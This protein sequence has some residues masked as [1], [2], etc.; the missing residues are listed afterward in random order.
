MAKIVSI[1]EADL[2]IGVWWHLEGFEVV[3]ETDT[4]FVGIDNDQNC[5]EEWGYL[6]TEDEPEEFVGAEL[7]EVRYTYDTNGELFTRAIEE[8]PSLDCG[9]VYFVTFVTSRGDFQIAA[10]NAHNGYYGH[11]VAYLK[12]G[13]QL[14]GETV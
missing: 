4:H 11:A 6:I 2:K 14:H 8:I 12:N 9:G 1:K 10:Y 5:C 3:T 13:K 7:L